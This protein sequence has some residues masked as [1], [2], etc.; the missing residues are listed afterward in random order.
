VSITSGDR[1]DQR[2]DAVG[3]DRRLVPAA[4]GLLAPAQPQVLAELEVTGNPRQR[5]HVHHSGAQLGEPALGEVRMV[6]EQ[7]LRDDDAEHGVPEELQ[8][9]VRRQP[10]VLVRERTVGEGVLQ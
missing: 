2:L 6:A 5:A 9:L 3:Q 4:G 1:A 10:T 8:P 7:R